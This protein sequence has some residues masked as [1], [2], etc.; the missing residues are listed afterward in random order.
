[1]KFQDSRQNHQVLN[2]AATI[3]EGQFVAAANCDRSVLREYSDGTDQLSDVTG[4]AAAVSNDRAADGSGNPDEMFHPAKSGADRLGDHMRQ[5]SS[6]TG[7]D[8]I[9]LDL[10]AGKQRLNNPDHRAAN[11]FFANQQIRTRSQNVDGQLL[12]AAC[13]HNVQEFLFGAR[14]NEILRRSA[15][16]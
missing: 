2:A 6:T 16:S 1:V 9:A 10:N 11:T 4:S 14:C 5:Q 12:L 13:L 7:G 8:E 3:R 15:Q